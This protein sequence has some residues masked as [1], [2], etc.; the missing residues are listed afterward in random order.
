MYRIQNSL[1]KHPL[2]LSA[3]A[4]LQ[5][6]METMPCVEPNKHVYEAIR[7]WLWLAM[8]GAKS[9]IFSGVCPD[10]AYELDG[11]GNPH[12]TFNGLGSGVGIV[13]QRVQKA[14]H[15]MAPFC[16]SLGLDV[17]FVVA[18][19]DQEFDSQVTCDRVGVSQE[20]ALR[21]L[22]GSQEEFR[23]GA[24]HG[25]PLS[26]YFMTQINPALW[27]ECYAQA[28]SIAAMADFL[29]QLMIPP[30]K[31]KD[32]IVKREPLMRK[33]FPDCDP[34][35][36]LQTQLSDYIAL[37]AFLPQQ[38]ENVLVLAG[39]DPSMARVLQGVPQQSG[40][41]LPVLYISG[42]AYC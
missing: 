26:T 16:E 6:M 33:W 12:Y 22:M 2:F 17:E 30:R 8:W 36:S 13:A 23:H 31:W 35:S 24:P 38:Y 9:T 10:Y 42:P 41:R 25:V 14:M 32:M 37:G 3:E 18:I 40:H 1:D 39:D 21:R 27:Q 4:T 5:Q 29:G 7:G 20:E 15:A 28:R 34:S 19:A 11:E